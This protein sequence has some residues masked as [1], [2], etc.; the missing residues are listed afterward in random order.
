M[1]TREKGERGSPRIETL[2]RV[3]LGFKTRL[4]HCFPFQFCFFFIPL[5]FVRKLTTKRGTEACSALEWEY[6]A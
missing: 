4:A 3:F 1:T 5:C 2:T 6:E